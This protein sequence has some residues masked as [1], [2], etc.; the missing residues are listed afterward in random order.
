[1]DNSAGEAPHVHHHLGAKLG[2]GVLRLRIES[3]PHSKRS[4]S[5]GRHFPPQPDDPPHARCM[6]TLVPPFSAALFQSL[7]HPCP[8]IEQHRGQ[9]GQES[10]VHARP[11]DL[12]LCTVRRRPCPARYFIPVSIG[13]PARPPPPSFCS[14]ACDVAVAGPSRQ[15]AANVARWNRA[16]S[17][18]A[19]ANPPLA[20]GLASQRAQSIDRSVG[21][22]EFVLRGN[23]LLSFITVVVV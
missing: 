12:C 22:L 18:S 6:P 3:C 21:Q 20:P 8:A 13:S 11:L 23:K 1:M 15:P 16:C 5:P 17:T 19:S 4:R 7:F 14:S 2:G 10:V 9:H